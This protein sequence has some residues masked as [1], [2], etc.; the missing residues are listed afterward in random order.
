MC[1][2]SSASLFY[3]EFVKWE[4]TVDVVGVDVLDSSTA[5]VS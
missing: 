2:C 4:L 5:D 3:V 1:L